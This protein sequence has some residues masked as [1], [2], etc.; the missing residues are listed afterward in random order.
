[1]DEIDNEMNLIEILSIVLISIDFR[2]IPYVILIS[3]FFQFY[4]SSSFST[5]NFILMTLLIHLSLPFSQNNK[6]N[7]KFI[8]R[9]ARVARI[10]CV[11]T[12]GNR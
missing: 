5:L 12:S 10:L 1:M 9:F 7:E 3:N 6:I 8:S 4:L 11:Y 2:A